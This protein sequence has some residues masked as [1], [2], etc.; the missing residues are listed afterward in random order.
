MKYKVL[1]T[2]MSVE[3]LHDMFRKMRDVVGENNKAKGW[4]DRIEDGKTV[5]TATYTTRNFCCSEK[6]A[7]SRCE[8]SMSRL[9]DSGKAKAIMR[10]WTIPELQQKHRQIVNTYESDARKE[11][12]D[13]IKDKRILSNYVLV[14]EAE[15]LKQ[16]HSLEIV[17]THKDVV[18]PFLGIHQ[19]SMNQV[20]IRLHCPKAITSTPNLGLCL[21][22]MHEY[23][24]VGEHVHS[25]HVDSIES[26]GMFARTDLQVGMRIYAID[27]ITFSSEEEGQG[28]L[29]SIKGRVT[30]WAATTPSRGT[31]YVIRR[32][33]KDKSMQHTVFVPDETNTRVFTHCQSDYH[34]HTAYWI[35]D[36][37]I[38]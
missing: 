10:D 2:V 7:A 19:S 15:E 9:K 12:E 32:K 17:S 13:A 25:L 6:G 34:I 21:T 24:E 11:I 20:A 35:R 33:N 18:N 37:Y 14:K 4:I 5:R 30:I 22:Y 36:R 8:V 27:G 28:L 23:D 31:V 29:K 26:D 16:V 3:E 1:Y 38:Q